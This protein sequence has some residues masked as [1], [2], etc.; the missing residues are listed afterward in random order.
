MAT[1]TFAQCEELVKRGRDGT[2]KLD[3]NTYL[4]RIDDNTF[5]VKLHSTFV[6][7]IN[8]DGTYKL[9]SGGW[10]TPTTKARIN[11]YS[12]ARIYQAKGIWYLSNNQTFEDGC[13][14]NAEGVR[15][16]KASE[17][18][19]ATEKRK[20]KLDRM[21]SKYIKGFMD[22]LAKQGELTAPSQGDCWG[23]FFK[24]AE[25]DSE[26][27]DFNGWRMSRTSVRDSEVMG[28]DHLLSH[29]KEK[30][31]VPSLLWK[32]ICEQGYTNPGLTWHMID[33]DLKRGRVSDLA[34]RA[35]RRYFM[36]RKPELMKLIK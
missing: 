6:V 8:R 15:I 23:C 20:R 30:Y 24:A 22:H 34:Q 21:V 32:A 10:Q 27:Q 12:P 5:G 9:E 35:L 29:F 33:A 28:F 19:E 31:Y 17:S 14:I 16:D 11:D 25:G 7:E 18:V 2:K 36:R 1:L 4:E 26:A 13:I 3:N